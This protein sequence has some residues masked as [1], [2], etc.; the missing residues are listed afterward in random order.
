MIFQFRSTVDADLSRLL[1]Q[2][3]TS[4]FEWGRGYAVGYVAAMASEHRDCAV[5]IPRSQV[6]A[7]ETLA[8]KLGARFA[9]RPVRRSPFGVQF[10]EATFT[11]SGR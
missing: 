3:R 9:T 8:G 6:P 4:D 7:M 2:L 11:W 5:E 1:G 10:L